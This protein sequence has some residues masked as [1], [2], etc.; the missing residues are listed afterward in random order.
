MSRLFCHWVR[1]GRIDW[2]D[3][4]SGRHF[5]FTCLINSFL[6]RPR[7]GLLKV[8]TFSLFNACDGRSEPI[9]GRQSL[10][11]RMC[12]RRGVAA[13]CGCRSSSLHINTTTLLVCHTPFRSMLLLR[14]TLGVQLNGSW[15]GAYCCIG[16]LSFRASGIG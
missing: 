7:A 12:K 14:K 10:D 13:K 3:L 9:G 16:V 1:I 8:L 11:V 4:V 15:S 6:W 2:L 5:L